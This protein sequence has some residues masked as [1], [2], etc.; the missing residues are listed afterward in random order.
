MPEQQIDIETEDGIMPTFTCWPDGEGPW[1]A[2]VFYMDAPAIREELYD[3][4]R[5]MA[6]ADL[7]IGAAGSTAWERCCLGLPTLLLVLAENQKEIG[8]ALQV[9]GAAHVLPV[10]GVLRELTNQWRVIARRHYLDR[11]SRSAASLVDGLGVDRVRSVLI[12]PE[13]SSEVGHG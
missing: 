11:L 1:P 2:I 3:M 13:L 7:A 4:A 9:K 10:A 5:R 8:R 12:E 6:E